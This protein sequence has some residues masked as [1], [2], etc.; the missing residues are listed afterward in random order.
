MWGVQKFYRDC[1]GIGDKGDLNEVRSCARQ[2]RWSLKSSIQI[3][4]TTHDPSGKGRQRGGEP[5]VAPVEKAQLVRLIGSS[6][7]RL[8]DR[9]IERDRCSA[10][11]IEKLPPTLRA[12]GR[13]Q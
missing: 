1:G 8:W 2:C 9:E 6:R 13:D 4:P 7:E 10:H 3:I 12:H 11:E 5:V